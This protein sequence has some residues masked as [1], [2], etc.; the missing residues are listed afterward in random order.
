MQNTTGIFNSLAA[1]NY[2]LEITDQYGCNFQTVVTVEA[3]EPL[4]VETDDL[5][6]LFFGE[7]TTLSTM[8]THTDVT[9]QWSPSNGL[10]C[11]NCPNPTAMPF[12][13]TDYTVVVQNQNGC[14][15]A[16]SVRIEVDDT[17]PL[18][19]PTAFSPNEDGINDFFEITTPFIGAVEAIQ[20]FKIFNRWGQEIYSAT[21]PAGGS[22]LARW[23]GRRDFRLLDLGVYVYLLEL[24]LI[25]GGVQTFSGTVTIVY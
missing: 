15:A 18:G 14:F 7:S 4:V 13:T 25:D 22:V 6:Q 3:P 21:E 1:G 16:D 9:Y 2:T 8:V 20:Q 23:D 11:T 17:F 19:I 5:I 10:S 12:E 24:Q